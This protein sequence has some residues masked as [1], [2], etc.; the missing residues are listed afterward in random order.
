MGLRAQKSQDQKSRAQQSPAQ[1]T[2]PALWERTKA[3]ITASGHGG[4]AGQWSARKAQMAVQKYKAAGGGYT[5]A[6]SADN[7]L[8]QWTAENWGTKSGQNSLETGERYLPA[9]TIA[10]LTDDQYRRSSEKKRA[11]LARGHQYSA[12][13]DDVARTVAAVWLAHLSHAELM[14]RARILAIPG[15]SRMT[16]SGLVEALS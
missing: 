8:S 12:Q 14:Q 9:E 7:H 16:K 2:D 5:G 13:P 4:V 6:K 11:D 1:K 15:R 3:E 10:R